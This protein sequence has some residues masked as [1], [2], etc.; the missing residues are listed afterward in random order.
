MEEVRNRPGVSPVV[1]YTSKGSELTADAAWAGAQGLNG[2]KWGSTNLNLFKPGAST[3]INLI[4]DL[5]ALRYIDDVVP[6]GTMG[7]GHKPV[8]WQKVLSDR[9]GA[10]TVTSRYAPAKDFSKYGSAQQ[11]QAL[12]NQVGASGS[13]SE[14][15][16][17]VH[18]FR[19][20]KELGYE[21]QDVSLHYRGN[22]GLDLLFS[23][24]SRNAV[25]EAKHGAYLS[26]LKTYKG[27]LRQGSLDYNISRLERYLQHGDGTHNNLAN[28][29]L[30]EA[31]MGQ[32][33][34]F[35][36]FYRSDRVLELPVGWPNVPAIP[37]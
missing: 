25:V 11:R 12:L 28:Q 13:S 4:D 36:T 1:Y 32:L 7:P 15:K 8:N 33:E 2:T 14:A 5:G 19:K 27:G 24:G 16:G 37:R 21:L 6:S 3:Q 18:S 22:Q 30:D 9:Y 23:N 31:Y 20:M 35:G 10:D 29:L 17:V 34:S 26:S